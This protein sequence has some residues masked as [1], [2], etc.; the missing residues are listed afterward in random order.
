[1]TRACLPDFALFT[2][3]SLLFEG[4]MVKPSTHDIANVPESRIQMLDTLL[5]SCALR[6]QT[7]AKDP[8]AVPDLNLRWHMKP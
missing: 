5:A 6:L 2:Q 3:I 4:T 7:C 1:M 8:T